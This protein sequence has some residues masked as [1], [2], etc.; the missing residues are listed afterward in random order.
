MRIIRSIKSSYLCCVTSRE[1]VMSKIILVTGVSTGFGRAISEAAI[2][3]GHKV[4][5]TVRKDA[6]AEAFAALGPNAFARI[7]DVTD[8]DAIAPL[9]AEIEGSVGPIDVLINNA[10]Y[11]SE[12]VIEETPFS[13]VRRQFEI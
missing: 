5:G 1:L 9:V 7:L 4:V 11:G 13:E 3:A 10:G 12:G 6:D 2:A 8:I